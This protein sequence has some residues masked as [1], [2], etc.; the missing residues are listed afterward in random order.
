MRRLGNNKKIEEMVKILNDNLTGISIAFIV[1]VT[2]DL[3][4]AGNIVF[5][6]RKINQ[7][8]FLKAEENSILKTMKH[9]TD[10]RMANH[11]NSKYHDLYGLYRFFY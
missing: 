2:T 1:F 5:E 6:N 4:F 9:V 10:W 3:L 11:N 7:E 8:K